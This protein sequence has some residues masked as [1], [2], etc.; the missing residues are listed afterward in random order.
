MPYDIITIGSAF[1]DVYLFSKKFKVL[2]N[3]K[4]ITGEMECF[5]FGTKIE[6][7][8]MH[9]EIGGGAVNTAATFKRQGFKVGC[10]ARI[11]KDSAGDDVRQYLKKHGIN[12]LLAI[13]R[14]NK[15]AQSVVFLAPNG[16][17]TILVYRGAAHDFKTSD[18]SPVITQAKWLY[19]T[20]LA[21]RTDVL[22]KII[23]QAKQKGV[24]VAF[25]P[26]K[27]DITKGRSALLLLLKKIDILIM[28]NEEAATLTGRPIT[29]ETGYVRKLRGLCPGILVIT[30]GA[31]GSVVVLN[32]AMHRVIIKP[33]KAIDTTGA[34]DAFG[35]GFV[36][37]YVRF[38]GD[39]NKSIQLACNNSAGEVSQLGAKNG[40]IGLTGPWKK[41]SYSIKKVNLHK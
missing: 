41:V 8:D 18:I 36:A 9:V 1:K 29:D 38:K 16:E 21:G 40:L 28:N 10:L 22:K 4:M 14:K 11:G 25:N 39:I 23:T 33:L 13:D 7:E 31:Q 5:A 20:S 19:V 3:V 35:S 34:G 24:R 6:L 32:G 15:T 2:K 37:G 30:K 26:G 12:D 27:L 17:R